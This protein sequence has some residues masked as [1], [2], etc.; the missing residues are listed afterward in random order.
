MGTGS[1]FVRRLSIVPDLVEDERFVKPADRMQHRPELREIIEAWAADK[2]VAE[3]VDAN[4][5]K[6][7]CAPVNNFEQVCNDPHIRDAREMFIDVPLAD[8][9]TMTITNNPIKMSDF[10]CRP[11]SGPSFAAATTTPFSRSLALTPTRLRITES[12]A[13]SCNR[14]PFCL[15]QPICKKRHPPQQAAGVFF[16]FLCLHMEAGDAAA[17]FFLER[18]HLSAAEVVGM[19]TS[20]AEGAAGGRVYGAWDFPLKGM[21]VLRFPST[22]SGIGTALSNAME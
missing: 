1:S 21:R 10:R 4:A 20:G 22:G 3:I 12:A 19:G 15:Q 2:T 6:F 14:M 16:A 7:P 13:S 9:N 8:G 11:L 17:S 18:R 5:A